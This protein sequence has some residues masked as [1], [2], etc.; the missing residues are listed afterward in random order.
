MHATNHL[1]SHAVHAACMAAAACTVARGLHAEMHTVNNIVLHACACMHCSGLRCSCTRCMQVD[2]ITSIIAS[3]T[4]GRMHAFA[5]AQ[6]I[7]TDIRDAA[8]GSLLLPS[9]SPLMLLLLLRP[10]QQQ[11]HRC[12]TSAAA[13]IV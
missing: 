12:L 5:A 7:Q 1:L 11:Q 4:R 13:G 3:C 8:K 10:Q 6:L 9:L 2:A